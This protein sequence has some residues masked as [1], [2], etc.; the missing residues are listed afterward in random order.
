VVLGI[1]SVLIRLVVFL[2]GGK[3]A[4]EVHLQI[5]HVVADV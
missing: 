1:V 4:E 3:P 5:G 2:F